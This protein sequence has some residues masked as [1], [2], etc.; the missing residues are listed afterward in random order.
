MAKPKLTE[1]QLI[2]QGAKA[3]GATP[4]KVEIPPAAEQSTIKVFAKHGRFVDLVKDVTIT[5]T[6]WL[7]ANIDNGLLIVC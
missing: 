5:S 6:P 7:Q 4:Q 1:E 3:S 2:A